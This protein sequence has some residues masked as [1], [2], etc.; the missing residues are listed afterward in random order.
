[1]C[2]VWLWPPFFWRALIVSSC[3]WRCRLWVDVLELGHRSLLLHARACRRLMLST[4]PYMD[5]VEKTMV[6]SLFL[7]RRARRWLVL[8]TTSSMDAAEGINGIV[9]IYTRT[10]V[11]ASCYW[12]RRP[13]VWQMEL[14]KRY[15][16][17]KLLR[18]CHKLLTTSCITV[19]FRTMKTVSTSLLLFVVEWF[20]PVERS[21][22]FRMKVNRKV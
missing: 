2:C 6:S 10:L 1:M 18:L 8:L 20:C 7:R 9:S 21:T 19:T 15:F 22:W 5:A 17:R 11:S 12:R 4:A 16:L 13:W 14:G 3:R